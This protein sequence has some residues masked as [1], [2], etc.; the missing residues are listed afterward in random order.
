MLRERGEE[1]CQK[2]GEDVIE[3]DIWWTGVSK[4]DAGE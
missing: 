3:S 2:K 4:K 1:E